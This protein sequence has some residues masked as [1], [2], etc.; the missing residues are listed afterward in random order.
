[1][2]R[3]EQHR[4]REEGKNLNVHGARVKPPVLGYGLVDEHPKPVVGRRNLLWLWGGQGSL[5]LPPLPVLKDEC[6]S[7][8]SVNH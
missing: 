6:K 1:M 3:Q 2:G 4:Q 5:Q 8:C 7:V